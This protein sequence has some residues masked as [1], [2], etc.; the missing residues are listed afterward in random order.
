MSYKERREHINFYFKNRDMMS[1]E[2]RDR[3]HPLAITFMQAVAWSMVLG[4]GMLWPVLRMPFVQQASFGVRKAIR[5]FTVMTPISYT[6]I[7]TKATTLDPFFSEMY[8]KYGGEA[9]PK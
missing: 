3:L 7:T 8:Q 5:F 6:Y 1:A 2:D 9:S 4:I